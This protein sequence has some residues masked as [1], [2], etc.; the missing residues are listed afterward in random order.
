[1]ARVIKR[2]LDEVLV[3]L[4]LPWFLEQLKTVISVT[5]F[6]FEVVICGFLKS[7]SEFWGDFEALLR[8]FLSVQFPALLCVWHGSPVEIGLAGVHLFFRNCNAC[9][10]VSNSPP[11]C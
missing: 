4:R 10:F 11:F 8:K 6:L 7:Q 3:I 9:L 2:T 5:C 1:M